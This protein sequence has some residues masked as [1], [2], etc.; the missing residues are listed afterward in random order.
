M[1]MENLTCELYINDYIYVIED[2]EF[3]YIEPFIPWNVHLEWR[4]IVNSL[5]KTAI[6]IIWAKGFERLPASGDNL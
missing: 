5:C 6:A 2:S 1:I 4:E 3:F